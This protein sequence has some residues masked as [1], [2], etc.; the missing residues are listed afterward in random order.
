M[1]TPDDLDATELVADDRPY[2]GWLTGGF[3]VQRS[4]EHNFDHAQL[5]I[6]VV[7][8]SM[9]GAEN[10][11]KFVHRILPN[12]VNPEGWDNQ[13]SNELAINVLYQHRWRTSTA[14][15]GGLELDAIPLAGFEFGN[16]AINA[17]AGVIGRVGINLPRDFGPGNLREFRDHTGSRPDKWELYGY[18]RLDAEAVAH[19]IFLDGN[20]FADSHSVEKKPLVGS[21]TLGIVFRYDW[22]RIGYSATYETERFDGQSGGDSYGSLS[23]TGTW[24]F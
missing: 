24:N 6:G 16:V 9:T 23:L 11:Q 19:D 22:F 12:Q 3:F 1:F 18:G 21:G 15:L 14:N 20:T 13:L 5:D 10:V 7:G 2:A 8:G 4:D 17:H